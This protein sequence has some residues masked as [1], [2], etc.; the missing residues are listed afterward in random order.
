MDS[1]MIWFIKKLLHTCLFLMFYIQ[2]STQVSLQIQ[3]NKKQLNLGDTVVTQCNLFYNDVTYAA[4]TLHVWIESTNGARTWKYRYPLINGKCL[5]NLIIDKDHAEGTYAINYLVQPMFFAVKGT[6][7]N[8]TKNMNGINLLLISKSYGN[9]NSLLQPDSTGTFKTGRIL[10]Y[11]TAQLTF[12]S[13][14][15]Q[16][17]ELLMRIETPLD[18]AFTPVAKH[19]EL[20]TIGNKQL[21]ADTAYKFNEQNFRNKAIELKEIVVIADVRAQTLKEFQKQNVTTLFRG[22]SKDFNGFYNEE[23]MRSKDIF[24]Y[25]QNKLTT[26]EITQ[27]GAGYSILQTG[28]PV[29]IFIDEVRTDTYELSYLHP[30]DVALVKIYEPGSGPTMGFGG[31]LAIYTKKGEDLKEALKQ[32]SVYSVYGY[33]PEVSIWK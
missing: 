11:D 23:M 2:A 29:D 13:N 33:S 32:R 7:R 27:R 8:Y 3:Q 5:F 16:G 10:F 9:H 30:G 12:T 19:I 24:Q 25:L 17:G 28:Y 14:I 15:K 22:I 20:I 26:L 4:S 6:V 1:Q 21:A 31:V 18:S